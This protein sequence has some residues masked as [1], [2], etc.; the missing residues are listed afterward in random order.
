MSHLECC[1]EIYAFWWV[2]DLYR[3]SWVAGALHPSLLRDQC[4]QLTLCSVLWTSCTAQAFT[5]SCA[6]VSPTSKAA[7]PPCTLRVSLFQSERG[8]PWNLNT[9]APKPWGLTLYFSRCFLS[10]APAEATLLGCTVEC[11]SYSRS[12]LTWTI[13]LS[14]CSK[15]CWCSE[16]TQNSPSLG[17]LNKDSSQADC[18]LAHTCILQSSAML[19]FLSC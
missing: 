12:H 13:P 14:I 16:P 3:D 15:A 1:P 4:Y 11:L 9:L 2:H 19:V 7:Q 8:E 17:S 18:N 5:R 6:S 10:G